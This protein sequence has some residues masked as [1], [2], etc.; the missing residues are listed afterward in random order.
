ML[1]CPSISD[2]RLSYQFSS[3]GYIRRSVYAYAYSKMTPDMIVFVDD[4][5][6]PEAGKIPSSEWLF[7]LACYKARPELNAVIHTHAVNST[8]V[9]IHNHSIPA[10]H[11][12]V[13]VSG[14]D[15]IPCIP[16]YTFGSPELADGVSKGIRESKSLLMQHHGMLAMD[17]TLEKTLW[18]AGETETLADLYIKC[19]G[20]HHDVPV[21]SEAEMTIVLEKFK[22]YGLKA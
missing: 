19:G 2:G 10:I 22:T 3:D 14:T 6:I 7:H 15:H 9:A 18:L 20:L 21:L 16:Y 12:M 1:R 11:Y 5:G 17:V 8:A 13:A 4:K